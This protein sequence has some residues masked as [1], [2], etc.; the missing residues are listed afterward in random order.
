M[1]STGLPGAARGARAVEVEAQAKVNLRLRILARETTGY[2]QLETLLL[3]LALSDTVRVRRTTAVRSLDAV[4]DGD[5]SAL[6]PPDRNLAWRA[7]EAYFAASGMDG[8][9][10]IEITKR[11][12][13]G[14]GLG[15]GS[16]DAGAVLR[17]LDAMADTP[18]GS[19][20]LLDIAAPLGADV[21]FLASEHAYALA[22]G[23]GARML[24]LTPPPSRATLL[25]VPA[26]G[27]DTTAAYGWLAD[28]RSGPDAAGDIG[29]VALDLEALTDWDR[30]ALL[31][32]N[33][34]E[35]VVATRY[36]EI[37]EHVAALRNF[38]C[39][40]AMLSGSGSTVFGV[41]RADALEFAAT[42][43]APM[44]AGEAR[45]I[46]TRTARRVEPVS[47]IE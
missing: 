16:A 40:V 37:A 38:D 14:G 19:P 43:R 29:A 7:A 5:I 31:T 20:S 24:A 28:S 3:R 9:F 46:E 36:P 13:V 30:L 17:A 21:P 41:A 12:P 23:R 32:E 11:I 44:P 33:D 1:S 8:G 10:A 42:A 4:G 15:G 47:V 25:I 2:H 45:Y 39:V 18:L 26:F 6:G 34:F 22:W 35:R 27:V